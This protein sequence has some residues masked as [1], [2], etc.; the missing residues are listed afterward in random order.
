M[1]AE[2]ANLSAPEANEFAVSFYKVP[3]KATFDNTMQVE[4]YM[5]NP[6]KKE[7]ELRV[8]HWGPKPAAAAAAAAPAPG[9][10][11]RVQPTRNTGPCYDMSTCRGRCKNPLHTRSNIALARAEVSGMLWGDMCDEE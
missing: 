2:I 11:T 5:W 8:E 1:F 4:T 10:K 6:S 7:L 3:L 9:P